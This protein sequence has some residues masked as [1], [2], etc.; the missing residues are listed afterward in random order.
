MHVF[1]SWLTLTSVKKRIRSEGWRATWSLDVRHSL[2]FYFYFL[3]ISQCY[4][5]YESLILMTFSKN[6]SCLCSVTQ[7]HH[8]SILYLLLFTIWSAH[9]GTTS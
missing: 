6:A 1:P 7:L 2:L 5:L 9:A 3:I 8:P 4:Y